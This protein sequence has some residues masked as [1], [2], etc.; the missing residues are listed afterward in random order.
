MEYLARN[1]DTDD[2]EDQITVLRVQIEPAPW[3]DLVGY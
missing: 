2:N 1:N 3:I